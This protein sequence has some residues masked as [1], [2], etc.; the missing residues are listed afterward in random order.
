MPRLAP[1]HA[2]LAVTTLAFH[3]DT[4][5]YCLLVPLLPRYAADLGLGPA[6]LSWLFGSYALALLAATLP[7]GRLSD[8]FGRRTPMLLGLAGLAFSTFAFAYSNSYGVLL[9]AR[10]MQGVAGAATWLPGMA[11]VADHWPSGERGKAMGIAFAGANLGLL[12]GP[13]LAG[14]LDAQFGPRAPFHLGIALVALDAFGRVFLLRDAPPV[15]EAPIP[16]RLLLGNPVIRVFAGAMVLG[17]G[18]WAFLESALPMDFSQRLG[19]GPRGIGLLFAGMALAHTLSSPWMGKLS[20]R[21]GR[22]RIL[23]IGLGSAALLLPLP[24]LLSSPLAVGLALAALGFNASFLL[25]PCSPAVADQ[26]ERSGSQ[27]FASGFGVLNLAYSL[28]MVAGPFLGG[29]L[30]QFLGLPWSMLLA[31]LGIGSYLA[32]VRGITA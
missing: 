9:L 30:V 25:S 24:A 29:M 6:K 21:F 15:R 11:L 1:R 27:S 22:A 12:L 17:S 10:A 4:L 32:A 2:A 3:V 26:V 5:L 18:L 14:F 23:R 28:G 13:P 20:D 31:G 16:W 7:I 19:L 8:R